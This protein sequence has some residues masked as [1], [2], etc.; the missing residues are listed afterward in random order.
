MQ[1]S[2]FLEQAT[3]NLQSVGLLYDFFGILILGVPIVFR[4]ASRIRKQAGTYWDFSLPTA[5]AL[6]S[7]TWDTFVGSVLLLF[8]FALQIAGSL[9]A[10]VSG[11]WGLVLVSLLILTVGLYWVFVRR[12][13]VNALCNRARSEG[14]AAD[15]AG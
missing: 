4:S 9:G 8:G 14:E 5:K 7:Q 11:E 13:L 15:S 12:A 1:V 6:S 10:N 3:T 2:A